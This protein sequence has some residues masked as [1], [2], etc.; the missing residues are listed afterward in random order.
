M[1]LLALLIAVICDSDSSET[2]FDV[3]EF[4]ERWET[5]CVERLR[6]YQQS[7]EISPTM[8]DDI[9]IFGDFL[10][11]VLGEMPKFEHLD[12]EDVTR[13]C[14]EAINEVGASLCRICFA[15]THALP[16]RMT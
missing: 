6:A 5:P 2:T 12:R 15:I 7:G 11:K 16:Y 8:S 4:R 3:V 1:H 10:K 13:I 9:D 14:W